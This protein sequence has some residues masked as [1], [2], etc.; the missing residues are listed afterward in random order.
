MG[1]FELLAKLRERLPPAGARVRLGS[2]D[3]AAVTVPGGATA[4]SVDAIVEG[5]HFRRDEAPLQTI[6]RKALATALSD[7][8]AMGAEAGEAYVVLGAPPDLAEGEFDAL[9]EGLLELAAATGTTLAGGDLTRAP[10]LT[11]AVTV[12]G[13]ASGA[14]DF[15]PRSGGR[16]GNVLVVTGKLGGAGAG[17][18][19]LDRPELGEALP[20]STAERLRSRQLDPIPRLRSGHAL[21]AAGATAMIDLS[22]GLAGDALHVA[23]ASGVALQIEAGSL[24]LAKGIAEVAAAASKEPL[25]LAASGGEDYELLAALPPNRLEEASQRMAEAAETTLTAIGRVSEGEGVEIRLPGGGLL[26]ARGYDHFGAQS[27]ESR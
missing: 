25:Q 22:D 8:A 1:E 14:S 2:G 16:P 19:L 23:R 7:L 15:V 6:G 27:R 3:D 26:E 5:V 10:G 13:H 4:T 18:L 12:V 11:L 9:L 24:P 20:E 21:A 17:R